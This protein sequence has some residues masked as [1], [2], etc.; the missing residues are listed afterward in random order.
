MKK[1]FLSDRRLPSRHA[2]RPEAR[3]ARRLWMTGSVAMVLAALMPLRDA[4]AFERQSAWRL[5]R[6]SR[7]TVGET[8]LRIEATARGEGLPVLVLLNGARPLMVLESSV[9]GTPVM[10]DDADSRP[11]MPLSLM[12]RERDGGGSEVLVCN[13]PAT[14]AASD[15][16]QLPSQVLADLHSLPELVASALA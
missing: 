14:Q 11:A 3:P 13:D 2:P 6:H 15:W 4:S 9:G 1:S 12:V 16:S 7:Y 8:V 5:L 10:M